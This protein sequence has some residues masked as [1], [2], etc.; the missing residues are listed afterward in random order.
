[1]PGPGGGEESMQQKKWITQGYSASR[2][3]SPSYECP[4]ITAATSF[5][6]RP[7]AL[8]DPPVCSLPRE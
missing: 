1:M 4:T 2:R 8:S 5:T 3:S 6:G 7:N